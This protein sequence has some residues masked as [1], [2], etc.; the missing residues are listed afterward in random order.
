MDQ[1]KQRQLLVAAV[2]LTRA[3]EGIKK[4]YDELDKLV[5]E[6]KAQGFEQ[7]VLDDS[8]IS[9]RDNFETANTVFRTAGVKRFELVIET[10]EKYAKR[11]A[12][13]E[14]RCTPNT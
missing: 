7:T 13:G 4:L 2:Q 9:I 3:I 10:S 6:L 5:L 8:V 1:T 11:I 12:K 14:K